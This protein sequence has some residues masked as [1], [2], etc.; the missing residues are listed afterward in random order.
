MTT[1]GGTHWT[2]ITSRFRLPAPRWVGKVLPSRIDARVAYVVFDGHNDDDLTPYVFRSSD[3]GA[4]WTSIAGDLPN[5][6]VAR[7]IEEHPRNPNVLFLGTEFG[8]VLDVRRRTP[9]DA[10]D[11]QHAAGACRSRHSQRRDERS[12]RRDA[13]SRD[14]RARRREPARACRGRR[15]RAGDVTLLPPRSAT[16][17]YE[18]RDLPWPSANAFVAPNPPVGTSITYVVGDAAAVVSASNGSDSSRTRTPPTAKIQIVAPDGQVV[19]ELSGSGTP[20]L[21][22]VLWDLRA[23][24]PFLPSASDSGYYGTYRGPFVLPGRYTV[25]LALAGRE[26]TQTVDVRADA[27]AV[28]TPAALAARATMSARITELAGI[29]SSAAKAFA[30]AEGEV[31]RASAA[32]KATPNVQAGTDSVVSDAARK[33]AELRGRLSPSYGTPVGRV[34]DLLGAIQSSS[35]APTEA[36]SRILDSATGESSR[37]DHEAQRSH[38]DD[39]AGGQD[40]TRVTRWRSATGEGA[41]GRSHSERSAC[42]EERQRREGGILI[43]PVEGQSA[44]Q[45]RGQS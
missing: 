17:T 41:V 10:C 16:P 30:A 22:R 11:R 20:G 38:H 39:A 35:G 4:T 34:F 1:D 42:P 27:R 18:W 2:N 24:V 33:V 25:K 44:R 15:S 8:S 9:L 6:T 5:G 29:Y 23:S 32:L 31:N 37:G 26:Q 14:H 21:H 40:T 43:V 3:G 36:E 28:T 19:R 7:T 45:R 13:R 12:H